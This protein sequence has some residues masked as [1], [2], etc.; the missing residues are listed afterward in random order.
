MEGVGFSKGVPRL[1]HLPHYVHVLVFNLMLCLY[2]ILL[3]Y[4]CY[5]VHIFYWIIC[6]TKEVMEN[7]FELKIETILLACPLRIVHEA[8]MF[9]KGKHLFSY[10]ASKCCRQSYNDQDVEYSWAHD[11]PNSNITCFRYTNNGYEQLWCWRPSRHEC[12]A[13]YVLW[14]IQPFWDC[15]QR[16]HEEIITD[17]CKC[18]KYSN[19]RTCHVKRSA[20]RNKS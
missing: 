5:L 11:S 16:R 19:N 20:L 3:C 7:K 9:V 15:L 17:N 8:T 10:L 18:W 13:R 4:F 6:F 12:S 2:Y 14:Q 1:L